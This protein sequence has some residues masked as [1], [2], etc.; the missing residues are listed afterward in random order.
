MAEDEQ[1]YQTKEAPQIFLKSPMQALTLYL[2]TP[3][4]EEISIIPNRIF[5]T[6]GGLGLKLTTKP[7]P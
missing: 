2:Q 7:K 5:S 3:R 1:S 4:S 6:N